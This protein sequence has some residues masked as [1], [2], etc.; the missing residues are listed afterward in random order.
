M[1]AEDSAKTV[2]LKDLKALLARVTEHY[3]ITPQ[4]IAGLMQDDDIPIDAFSKE[5]TVLETATKYLHENKNKTFAQIS[6]SIGK[7]QR[8]V[9]IAYM[10]A[11]AK[12]P[13]KIVAVSEEAIPSAVFSNNL[14]PLEAVV[15]R[16]RETGYNVR[17]IAQIICRSENTVR[18]II[19]RVGVKLHA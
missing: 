16:L 5:L 12:N 11:A 13:T 10:R 3:D 4:E 6:R 1:P 2:L 9:R 14:S 19:R 7:D 18:T 15:L 8:S 17:R